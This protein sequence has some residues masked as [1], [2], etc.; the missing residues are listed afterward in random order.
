MD[1]ARPPTPSIKNQANAC[2]DKKITLW[3]IINVLWPYYLRTEG[4]VNT[5]LFLNNC[6]SHT[7]YDEEKSKLPKQNF[8]F[9]LPPNVNNT[10]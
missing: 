4:D 5:I 1:G 3:W 8:S 6:S 10:N 7:I 2:I 9:F